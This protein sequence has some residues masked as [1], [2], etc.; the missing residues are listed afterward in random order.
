MTR[1]R[2]IPCQT[3]SSDRSTTWDGCRGRFHFV[4]RP[5][6]ASGAL[7]SVQRHMDQTG[8]CSLA[9]LGSMPPQLICALIAAHTA[10]VL[11]GAGTLGSTVREKEHRGKIAQQAAVGDMRDRDRPEP[12]A[13]LRTWRRTRAAW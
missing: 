12:G 9:P 10:S 1:W 5:T 8:A 4:G 7:G 6:I 11:R 13:P 2:I 3:A